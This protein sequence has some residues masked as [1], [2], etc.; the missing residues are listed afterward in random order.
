MIS[1]YGKSSIYI[2]L[3]KKT[4]SIS[5][6]ICFLI[7]FAAY[8]QTNKN[9]DKF[10]FIYPVPNSLMVSPQTNIIL[11]FGEDIENQTI[12]SNNISVTGSLSGTHNGNFILSDDNKTLVFNP[13]SLFEF[14]ETVTVS[15]KE[16]IKTIS[17]LIIPECAFNFTIISGTVS[18]G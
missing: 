3:F 1:Y 13:S 17:G 14:N 18:Q 2:S 5:A 7:S 15:L 4:F 11:R 12:S 8:P 9:L 10:Q 6:V 16:G